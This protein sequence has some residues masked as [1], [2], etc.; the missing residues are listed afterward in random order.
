MT[1]QVTNSFISSALHLKYPGCYYS[2]YSK[3]PEGLNHSLQQYV[4]CLMHQGIQP[5]L[6]AQPRY[7]VYVDLQPTRNRCILQIFSF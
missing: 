3:N 1:K 7:H 2:D 5:S 4:P 6:F